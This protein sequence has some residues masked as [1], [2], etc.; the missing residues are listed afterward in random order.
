MAKQVLQEVKIE[1]LRV[2]ALREWNRRRPNDWTW[3]PLSICLFAVIPFGIM[4]MISLENHPVTQILFGIILA[5]LTV[6]MAVGVWFLP[7][8][9]D[10]ARKKMLLE[11]PELHK[12]LWPD[13]TF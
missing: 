8:Q 4:V 3:V 7:R 6:F 9:E 10:S 2:E 1:M 5:A 11:K 13:E 12:A